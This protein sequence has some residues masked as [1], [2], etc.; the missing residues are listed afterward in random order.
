MR[1]K[2]QKFSSKKNALKLNAKD[3][4]CRSKAKAKPQRRELADYSPRIVPIE[5]RNWIDIET[6]KYSL[7]EYEVSKKVIY[8]LRHS[9]QV[10]REEDGAVHFWS[11][12]ENLQNQFPQS[13]HWPDARWKARLVVGGGVKRRFQYCTDDS[14]AIVCL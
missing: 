5:R 13:I 7:S 1:Q 2:F 14:G 8:L 9:Q 10:H 3:F 6:G 4:A 11:M 12:K